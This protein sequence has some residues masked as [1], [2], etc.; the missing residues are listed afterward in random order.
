MQSEPTFE[1]CFAG[2]VGIPFIRK[3]WDILVLSPILLAL[4]SRAVTFRVRRCC[5]H[6]L[7]DTYTNTHP[8]YVTTPHESVCTTV[9][10]KKS[11]QI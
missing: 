11:V 5:L 7:P 2:F 10:G 4:T 9:R 1:P 6:I 3:E 8:I